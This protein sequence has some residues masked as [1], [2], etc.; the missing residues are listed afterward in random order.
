MP[1]A[2]G[3]LPRNLSSWLASIDETFPALYLDDLEGNGWDDPVLLSTLTEK[4]LELAGVE[5]G[6]SVKA[7]N[8]RS[9]Q[10]CPILTPPLDNG[11]CPRPRP[12]VPQG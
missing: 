12:R 4:D 10:E 7:R 11:G 5:E 9:A 2:P 1:E 8:P 3:G 6:H